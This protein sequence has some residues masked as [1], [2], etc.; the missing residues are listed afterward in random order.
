M[1]ATETRPQDVL[2]D[3]FG[4]PSFRPG[5]EEVIDA[6]LAGRSALAV[7]P[8]G[9]G[10]SLCYQLPALLLDGVTLVVSPLIALMKD[11]IDF[12]AARGVAA[13]RLDSSLGAGRVRD[14]DGAAASGDAEAAL[15]RPG[16]VQQRALPGTARAAPGSRCSP[17]TR[18]TA[19]PSGA[20]TSGPTT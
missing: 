16:A 9:G 15:R 20:T 18:R 14:V 10:K 1:S 5:Q 17:W 13:A 19:S 6:L 7:F 3:P 12:L 2:A 11:Q 8:T 4:F